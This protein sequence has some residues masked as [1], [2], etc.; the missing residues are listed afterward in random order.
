MSATQRPEDSGI[1]DFY[2]NG[3]K[4]QCSVYDFQLDFTAGTGPDAPAPV[5]AR[6]HMSPQLAK[7]MARLLRFNIKSFEQQTG[8]QIALPETLLKQ[9]QIA[10]LEE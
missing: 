4:F 2:A 6:I 7:V 1:P 9:L 8:A 10:D 3:V 5:V